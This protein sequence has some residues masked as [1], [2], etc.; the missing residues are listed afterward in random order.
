MF[1]IARPETRVALLLERM[2]SVMLMAISAIDFVTFLLFHNIKAGCIPMWELEKP[3]KV[4]LK[5]LFI[6]DC[7]VRQVAK[8]TTYGAACEIRC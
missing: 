3:S 5:M 4:P 8:S 1:A 7:S 2:L 6:V